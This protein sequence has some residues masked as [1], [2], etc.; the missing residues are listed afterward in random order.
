VSDTFEEALFTSMLNLIFFAV[1][2]AIGWFVLSLL[3]LAL[4]ANL[5]AMITAISLITALGCCGYPEMGTFLSLEI[6][7]ISITN[8]KTTELFKIQEMN[9]RDKTIIFL[10]LFY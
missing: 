9:H 10:S 3:S 8:K 1:C 7:E 5:A 2:C 4:L 6:L